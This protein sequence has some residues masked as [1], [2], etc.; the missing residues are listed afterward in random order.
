MINFG[1]S[2]TT[3]TGGI[4]LHSPVNFAFDGSADTSLSGGDIHFYSTA[5]GAKNV[6]LISGSGNIFFDGVVG[7][8]IPLTSI[9]I[10]SA[11]NVTAAAVSA[12][13]I[14]QSAGSGV[15]TFN[16]AL[17]QP[18]LQEFQSQ[19]EVLFEELLL[20]QRGQDLLTFTLS[21]AGTLT[22]TAAGAISLDGAFTETGA[23]L[24]NLSGSIT[25]TNDN[26]SFGSPITLAGTTTFN[27]GA[28]IG[29]ITVTSV[30]GA[31]ALNI[32]AGTGNFTASRTTLEY[33]SPWALTV[34]SCTNLTSQAITAASISITET[35]GTVTLNGNLNTNAIAGIIFNI[36][37]SVRSGSVTATNGG[38]WTV[39]FSGS[40][41]VTGLFPINVGSLSVTSTGVGAVNFGG[42]VTTD[43][44]GVDIHA[45]LNFLANGGIDTSLAG[46]D[47]HFYG[48]VNGAKNVTMTAGAGNI[49][50][51]V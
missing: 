49:F 7:G 41:T 47:I 6:T 22:S 21:P 28:G 23:S 36:N 43:T 37:N 4:D 29:D 46:G 27:S 10:T 31:Q 3:D 30:N 45:P 11:N 34:N 33:Y 20:Q 14:T 42:F 39:V 1:G 40:T 26:I 51:M 15:T 17:Q 2:I 16:G 50:F 8:V 32:T 44:G 12:G 18:E 48:T 5:N 35:G 24:V 38:P 19:Q 9:T 25:T 13:S